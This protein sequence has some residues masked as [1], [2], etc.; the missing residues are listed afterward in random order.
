M[1]QI[2]YL[3]YVKNEE[4]EVV[5]SIRVDSDCHSFVGNGFINHNTECRLEKIGNE[6]IDGLKEKIVDFQPNFDEEEI[7]PVV[8]PA[9]FPNLLVN[10]T[11]GIAVGLVSSIP[12]HNLKDCIDMLIYYMKK[13]SSKNKE[14]ITSELL[15]ILKGPDFPTG[16]S[17]VN[18]E[19]LLDIYKTGEG[20]IFIRAKL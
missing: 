19:D 2:C 15:D 3:F 16:G 13:T 17:I 20:K 7:E 5:Y 9:R 1:S 8:L 11:N 18:V 6:L 4:K 14:I 10:G 12:P